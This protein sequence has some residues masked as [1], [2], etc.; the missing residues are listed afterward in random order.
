MKA[1]GARLHGE[2]DIRIDTYELPAIKE[3]EILAKVISNSVCM[4]TYKAAKLG[5]KHKRV[6]ENIAEHPIVTGHEFSGVIVEVGSKWADQFQ[7]GDKF[8]IQPAL[9]Y[10]GSP[11]S[12]GYSYEFFGGNATYIV[13]PQEVMTLGCLLKYEGESYSNA[14]L[15]E[16]MSCIIGAYHANYHTIPFEYHHVMGIKEGGRLALLAAAGPMGLG[17]IDYIL[18]TDRRPSQVVVMDIDEE[19]LDLAQR[20]IPVDVARERGIE[21]IYVNGKTEDDIKSTLMAISNQEGY[22]DVFVYAPVASVVELAD[23]LLAFDGCLNFF[24]GPIDNAFS[25]KFNFY[26]VHY[27]AT[28]LVGT[29]GGNTDDM[30]ESLAMTAK[31]TLNPAMMVTHVGGLDVVPETKLNLPNI[32]GGKKLIYPH[33]DM[34]LIDIRDLSAEKEKDERFVVLEEIL[35]KT[36]QIWSLEAETYVME[37]FAALE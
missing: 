12:P 26:H 34:P 13:I 8:A 15:A 17:A 29:S 4:S 6:P 35:T 19:R 14:S 33:I 10:N 37:A 3:D 1:R 7:V 22:D 9:N 31:G 21:L 5:S 2:N 16:P 36:H 25:A 27:S 20:V 24:A 11:Y 28:H 32:P 30:R 18:N 23:S